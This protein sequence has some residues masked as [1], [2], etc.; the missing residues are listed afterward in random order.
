M[1][2][3]IVFISNYFNHHQRYLCDAWEKYTN[4]HFVFLESETI[5]EERLAMG[6]GESDIPEY[7]VSRTKYNNNKDKYNELINAADVV[8]I[9]SAPECIISARKRS[10][11]LIFRYSERKFKKGIPPLKFLYWLVKYQLMNWPRKNIYLLCA[12]AYTSLDY[13]KLGL[14]RNRAFKWGYFPQF[15]RYENIDEIIREKTP[16]SIVWVG[17]MID[18]KHP[19]IPIKIAKRL[20]ENGYSFTMTMI[21][22]GFL[23]EKIKQLIFENKLQDVI[24]LTGALTPGEVRDKMEKSEIFIST[25]DRQEGWGAVINEAMNS[26]CAVIANHEI[27]AAPYLISHGKN[28]FMYNSEDELYEYIVKMLCR[29][30]ARESVAR[31]AYVSLEREWNADIAAKRFLNLAKQIIENKKELDLPVSGPCSSSDII[32]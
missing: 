15:R 31:N 1:N 10:K 18:W 28:G 11:K 6:W 7:V 21:G 30:E 16:D 23:A 14:F 13:S 26:V 27:G 17:R 22:V 19:E 12:S 8:I 24:E 20:K 9:G 3:S 2:I 29:K 32:R 4:G 5:T 25:S